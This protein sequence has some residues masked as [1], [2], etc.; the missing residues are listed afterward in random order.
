[1]DFFLK[2]RIVL[3]RSVGAIMLIVGF[4]AYFWV[5]PKEGLT[6]NER[7][8]ANVARM[9]ARSSGNKPSSK[10]SSRSEDSKFLQD[11]KE[12]QAKQLEYLT[13][14]AMILGAGFIGYT[15]VGKKD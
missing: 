14:I 15:F 5:T 3:V 4:A 8:M 13:I 7:A 11:L 1:M 10:Q 9:E 2:N 6:A 12:T